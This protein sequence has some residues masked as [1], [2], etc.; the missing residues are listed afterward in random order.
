MSNG[1]TYLFSSNLFKVLLDQLEQEKIR[2]AMKK[3]FKI[4]ERF[5]NDLL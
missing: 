4:D 5:Q 2:M 1:Q 3:P